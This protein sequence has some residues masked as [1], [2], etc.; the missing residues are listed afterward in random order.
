MDSDIRNVLKE[1][2]KE[3]YKN[4]LESEG[5]GEYNSAATLYFKA[6]AALA[7]LYIFNKENVVPS[8]HTKRFRI[9]EEKYF[10]IYQIL[11]RDFSFYQNSYTAKM[12]K[13]VCDLLKKDVEKLFKITS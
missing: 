12:N 11:D 8:S 2:A 10:E 5:R 7:D 13:E 9:F 1:N 4:A 6:L 3:Y